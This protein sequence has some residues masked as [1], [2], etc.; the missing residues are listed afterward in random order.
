MKQMP[1]AIL[2]FFFT[3]RCAAAQEAPVPA[4]SVNTTTT[5]GRSVVY[6]TTVEPQGGAAGL[7]GAPVAVK[8][9]GQGR[10][11]APSIE[12]TIGD[13][14]FN[15][16]AGPGDS[17]IVEVNGNPLSPDRYRLVAEG[18]EILSQ[19]GK[20]IAQVGSLQ[21]DA[22]GALVPRTQKM[23]A[24]LGA[25]FTEPEAALAYQL[26]IDGK[27]V[28][29]VSNIIDGSPASR[30]GLAAHDLVT[31]VDGT[32]PADPARLR[33]VIASKKPGDDI[34]LQILRKQKEMEI[35]AKLGATP[36]NAL[37]TDFLTGLGGHFTLS[38][39]P[40]ESVLFVPGT[41]ESRPQQEARIAAAEADIFLATKKMELDSADRAKIA[42]RSRMLDDENLKLD[43]R[44]MELKRAAEE[45][46]RAAAAGVDA[47][48]EMKKIEQALR[49]ME[50][51]LL[52]LEKMLRD[53]V[54][55]IGEDKK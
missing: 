54:D 18:I 8:V 9:S 5:S 45:K 53:T 17:T 23:R 24:F 27:T 51:R 3:C 16:T 48:D 43:L 35:A 50:E 30:A 21:R 39:F 12:F 49:R 55:R 42:A 22:K 37:A 28:S 36:A 19:D 2:G 44:K 7:S 4:G 40:R 20:V 10:T 31:Q 41:A 34:K 52:V 26:G 25:T 6:A 13:E 29:L 32:K 33:S 14:K 11:V 1:L 47:R 15:I 38:G 46:E